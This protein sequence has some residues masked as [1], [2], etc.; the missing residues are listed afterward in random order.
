KRDRQHAGDRGQRLHHALES[1]NE[2]LKKKARTNSQPGRGQA[3]R[4]Q[5]S[6]SASGQPIEL[7]DGLFLMPGFDDRRLAGDH[8]MKHRNLHRNTARTHPKRLLLR[9]KSLALD[10][11]WLA[12]PLF[13]LWK[14]P[15]EHA[16]GQQEPRRPRPNELSS[17]VRYPANDSPALS[18]E[19][20]I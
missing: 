10:R 9:I 2:Q 6:G 14:S 1:A 3:S 4:Q 15:K 11:R 19:M 8:A 12:E 16:G 13:R 7:I 20:P 5:Y 18:R 17:G